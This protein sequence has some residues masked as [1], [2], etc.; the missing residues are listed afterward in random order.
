MSV[1]AALTGLRRALQGR[2]V[3]VVSDVIQGA[4]GL[5]RVLAAQ[6]VE[7]LFLIGGRLGT[8]KLPEL[9]H[10]IL[11]LPPRSMMEAIHQCQDALC[12]LPQDVIER[13]EAFDPEGTAWVVGPF[14][15]RGDPVAG[16]RFFGARP[17]SWQA[18]EDK[19]RIEPVWRAAGIPHAPSVTL[20]VDHDPLWQAHLELD[21]G[22]GTVWAADDR[23]GFHGGAQGTFRVRSAED[24]DRVA[25]VLATMADGARVQPFLE[26]IP[27]S[28]HG[29]VFGDS[30]VVLRPAEMVVLRR[31][32]GSGFLYMRAGTSW[33][34]PVVH[35]EAM[36]TA[37][38]RLGTYL[39]DS[40]GYRGAF[41]LDGVLTADGF[42]PTECNPRVG[43][44]MAL[45]VPGFPF[46]LVSNALVDGLDLGSFDP[47]VLES[48]LL[49]LADGQR[50]A[51]IGTL[52]DVVVTETRFGWLDWDGDELVS[53]EEDGALGEWVLGPGPT[54]GFLNFRFDGEKLPVGPSIAPV[55]AAFVAWADAELGAGLGPVEAAPDPFR[56]T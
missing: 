49:E 4:G 36:R 13:I 11:G 47:A 56:S 3:I 46:A 25:T 34:P 29:L 23:E 45:M 32:Q 55:A 28:V 26:G 31:S 6:G 35:R 40:V 51:S 12:D 53:C 48:E 50:R 41:T 10:V 14:F 27:C 16:R 18:L 43:A 22:H 42:F 33:D 24:A 52:V 20:S 37:A 30:V 2:R 7:E 19:L 1:E 17:A 54:G 5:A 8:G 38:R 44:A 21:R 39:S 15:F 9:P